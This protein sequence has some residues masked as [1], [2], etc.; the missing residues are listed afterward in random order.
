[1]INHTPHITVVTPSLNQGRFI[2]DAIRSVLAQGWDDTEHIIVDAGST[3]ETPEVL[4]SYPHLRVI[5]EPDDG[6][7]DALN[8]GFLA[9]RGEFA[10]WLNAD[11]FL[12]PGAFDT[13][14]R[15]RR[16]NPKAGMF[17]GHNFIVDEVGRHIRSMRIIPFDPGICKYY[18][19]YFPSSGSFYATRLFQEMGILLDI[20]LHIAMDWDLYQKILEEE[21]PIIRIPAFLSGFRVHP[22]NK[23]IGIRDSNRERRRSLD[24][25]RY[26]ERRTIE[27]RYGLQLGIHEV[28]DRAAV[29]VMY[30]IQHTRLILQ[31]ALRLYYLWNAVDRLVHP[32]TRPPAP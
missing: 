12:L 7:S 19:S 5:R 17:Y 32:E 2:G 14:E 8:K 20:D 29:R 26:R 9:A 11:D 18:G 16:H 4:A 28:I 6:Q 23:S 27:Q 22:E 31:K 15:Y 30:N 3:D 1:M 21:V 13:F 10:C 24:D 25:R